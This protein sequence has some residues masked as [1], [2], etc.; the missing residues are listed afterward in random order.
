MSTTSI[1]VLAILIAPASAIAAT[2]HTYSPGANP[3]IAVTQGT[4]EW[5]ELPMPASSA[6]GDGYV[7]PSHDVKLYVPIADEQLAYDADRPAPDASITY[8]PGIEI[9]RGGRATKEINDRV[10]E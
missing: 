8:Y 9:P 6:A 3:K 4:P 2:P 10:P 1:A 5:E 7:A